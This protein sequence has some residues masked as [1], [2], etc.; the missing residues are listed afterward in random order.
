MTASESPAATG[1]KQSFLY[2]PTRSIAGS[3]EECK[4]EFLKGPAIFL[5][6]LIDAP[7]IL[8]RIRHSRRRGRLR[9]DRGAVFPRRAAVKAARAVDVGQIMHGICGTG[10][11][12]DRKLPRRAHDIFAAFG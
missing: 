10:P 4:L 5:G 2:E 11:R 1:G 3:Y 12:R 8:T 7:I 9:E 6:D